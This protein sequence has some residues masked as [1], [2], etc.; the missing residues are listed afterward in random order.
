MGGIGNT[1]MATP[2]IAATRKLYPNA[3]IDLLTTPAAAELLSTNPNLSNVLADQSA[4]QKG[5]FSYWW[6]V[7]Q[8]RETRYDAALATLNAHL[9]KFA[10]RIIL[11]RIPI[12][13]MHE[14]AFKSY[15]DFSSAYNHVVTRPRGRH[16]AACNCDLLSELSGEICT[17]GPLELH[18][19][20][21]MRTSALNLL[22]DHALDSQRKTIALCPGS[23]GWMSFKR[24]PSESAMNLVQRLLENNT[25]PNVV[26]LF[27]PEEKR[28]MV[29]W[30]NRFADTK[31]I[32]LSISSLRL[33]AAVIER[34]DVVVAND[35][36]PMHMS[37]A[38]QRPVVALFGPTD[39][40][41]TGPWQSV[42]SVLSGDAEYAP[43]YELPY[44]YD[45]AQF[46][47]VMNLI[48]VDQVYAKILGYVGTST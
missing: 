12:R 29:E 14:Y 4:S 20:N 32:L 48:S 34:M 45:P 18:L 24:W 23:S 9:S 16:D 10:T 39:P 21:R 44:P 33:L 41:H 38:L 6:L 17:A 31:L 42:A 13:I 7:K 47:D 5:V 8:I 1:L 36:L 35:S 30:V 26:V 2:L 46:P 11:G 15:D 28:I 40:R 3:Q 43:Y 22:E 25:K 19:N 37:A 27:G